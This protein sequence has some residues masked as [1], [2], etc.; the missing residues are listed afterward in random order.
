MSFDPVAV[1][2][3]GPLRPEVRDGRP[4]VLFN[5]L[6]RNEG[7]GWA[8]ASRAYARA[9]VLGG[10]DVRLAQ[11]LYDEAPLSPSVS[12]EVGGMLRRPAEWDLYVFST[13]LSG[14][15]HVGGALR[16]LAAERGRRAFYCVFERRTVEPAIVDALN[17]L[18]SVWVQCRM[19]LDV[20]EL[21]GVKNAR[22]IPF[23]FFD[24]DPHLSIPPTE[25]A[26]VFYNI[27]RFE[28]RKDPANLVRAFLRAFRP[29]EAEL[30]LK[31]SPYN[32][33]GF[34][35]SPERAV[36]F[37]VREVSGWTEEEA[38]RAIRVVT[39]RLSPEEMV[40]L[41]AACDVYVSASRGEGL[42]LPSFAAKLSGR[43]VVTTASGG[44][45]DF[46]DPDVDIVVPATGTVPADPAYKW[47][48]G[49]DYVDYDVD[50]LAR[51]MRRAHDEKRPGTRAW[52]GMEA[53]R[54]ENVGRALHDWVKEVTA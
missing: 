46:L 35:P 36:R 19:N 47:G 38:W 13:T 52:P 16:T 29:G 32:Y 6:F 15:D 51:A 17:G 14:A 23:P 49:A 1:L 3:R 24:D 53:H 9:M 54:A 4:I 43:R 18:D 41:H 28:P 30:V 12:S 45:E 42:D 25:G 8:I 22:L 10:V 31:T 21:A 37:A 48:E 33:W 2:S 34:Y 11:W 7:D 20:L 44:P 27:G 26:T 39:R 5:T 40:G 50:E